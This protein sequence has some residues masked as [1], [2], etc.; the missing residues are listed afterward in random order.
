[1]K[2]PPG[3]QPQQRLVC[4]TCEAEFLSYQVIKINDKQLSFGLQDILKDC[5]VEALPSPTSR[6]AML[7]EPLDS[8]HCMSPTVAQCSSPLSGS[9]SRAASYLNANCA[10][11][12]VS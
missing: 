12:S 4:D 1:M 8:N 11:Q 6:A 5:R 9:T 3:R 2:H 10:T 7:D